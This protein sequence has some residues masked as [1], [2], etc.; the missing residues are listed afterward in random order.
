[1]QKKYMKKASLI[2]QGVYCAACVLDI[3]LCLV[4]QNNVETLLGLKCADW[5]LSLTIILFFAPAMPISFI[6]NILAMPPKQS[7]R[8]ERGR[9]LIWTIISPIIY[10]IFCISVI[11]IFVVTTGGI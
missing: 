8:A 9:W 10:L 3:I 11:C 5:A 4:Y 2:L 6:L 7:E 1:M